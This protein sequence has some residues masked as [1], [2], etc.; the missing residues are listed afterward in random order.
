MQIRKLTTS[1]ALAYLKPIVP[2]ACIAS[3]MKINRAIISHA[4][5]HSIVNGKPYYLPQDKVVHLQEAVQ[6]IGKELLGT[7]LTFGTDCADTLQLL[8]QNYIN[9]KYLTVNVMGKSY[10]WMNRR[11]TH[12]PYT[13]RLG[14]TRDYYNT[15]TQ[16]DIIDINNA[17]RIIALD[18]LSLVISPDCPLESQ[19]LLAPEDRATP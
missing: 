7:K 14:N 6:N 5:S 9:I 16:K 19:S 2:L 15:F 10:P 17:I 1:E 8:K 12:L 11:M 3:E 13:D 18:I 4:A